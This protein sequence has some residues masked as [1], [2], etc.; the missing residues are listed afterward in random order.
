MNRIV[1]HLLLEIST[2][3]LVELL[4]NIIGNVEMRQWGFWLNSICPA[5]LGPPHFT[6]LRSI[7]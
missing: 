4:C 6:L 1:E 2:V 7:Y 3:W 5:L